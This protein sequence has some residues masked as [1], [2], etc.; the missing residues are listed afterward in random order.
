MDISCRS[1]AEAI[2]FASF[3]YN[4]LYRKTA[5]R[6]TSDNGMT[7]TQID[8]LLTLDTEGPMKMSDLSDRLVIAREQAT[9]TVNSLK[10]QDLVKSVR[11]RTNRKNV[12]ASI[13]SK[14]ERLLK[15]HEETSDRMLES[16]LK[17]LSSEDHDGLVAYS[18]AAADI[19]RR[20]NFC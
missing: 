1:D 20:N 11:S 14:G 6:N 12:V 2:R 10:E 8:I 5:L 13:T 4:E 19:L 16:Y 9:R 3:Y 7:K 18:K 15:S 17:N